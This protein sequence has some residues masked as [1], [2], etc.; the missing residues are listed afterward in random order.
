MADIAA[1]PPPFLPEPG[2]PVISWRDSHRSFETYLLAAGCYEFKPKRKAALFRT[3]LGMEADR[4]A[5]IIESAK[6]AGASDD[7][8]YKYLIQG[9]AAHFD[10]ST[11][12]RVNRIQ[13]RIIRQAEAESA[14]DFVRRVQFVGRE[15]N[16]GADETSSL[17][18]QLIVRVVSGRT[19]VRL[20]VEG[21][22]L[23]FDKAIQIIQSI[24]EVQNLL[25]QYRETK[26]DVVQ[27]TD[28]TQPSQLLRREFR[29]TIVR[30]Q[31]SSP[32]SRLTFFR[33]SGRRSPPPPLW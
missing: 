31:N 26:E 13:L 2:R 33:T 18:D 6:P 8:E 24:A 4:I 12:Q 21:P 7:H 15:C 14:L 23:T 1:K 20:L 29:P 19:R 3:F 22:A 17:V 25:Q 16:F 28:G 9:L 32:S 30:N 10:D 27:V 11:S 5:H